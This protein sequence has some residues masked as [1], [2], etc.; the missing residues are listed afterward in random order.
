[1]GGQ[2]ASEDAPEHGGHDEGHGFGQ[3]RRA[4]RRRAGDGLWRANAVAGT[5][6]GDGREN[7]GRR[8]TRRHAVAAKRSSTRPALGT[9]QPAGTDRAER[10]ADLAGS[11]RFP[12]EEEM[13]SFVI[14]S[15]AKQ[16]MEPKKD[17]IASSLRSSQRREIPKTNRT[18]FELARRT[19][20]Q[21][22]CAL[23]AQAPRTVRSIISSPPIPA[24]RATFA[25]SLG[26]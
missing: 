19:K 17:W 14:A 15:A 22:L 6:E 5:D 4:C 3:G 21:L 16:S 10:Q 2:Q 23:L 9:T 13:T 25:S 26:A 1:R 7:A 18:R 24:F 11:R 8:R 20:C 12:G